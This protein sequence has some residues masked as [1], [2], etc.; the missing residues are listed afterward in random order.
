MFFFLIQTHVSKT[1]SDVNYDVFQVLPLLSS[2]VIVHFHDVFSGFEYPNSWIYDENRSWNE[3]YLL[4][5]FLMFNSGFEYFSLTMTSR[6][7]GVMSWQHSVLKF[8]LILAGAFG[9]A[10]PDQA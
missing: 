4:R 8:W 10:G 1:G 7:T 6:A 5:A 9:F 3:Q 2:G